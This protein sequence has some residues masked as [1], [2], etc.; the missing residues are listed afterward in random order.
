MRFSEEVLLLR[1]EMRQTLASLKWYEDLWEKQGPWHTTLKSKPIIVGRY[2]T[3]TS[4]TIPGG[5]PLSYVH[6]ASALTTIFCTGASPSIIHSLL[7][8]KSTRCIYWM[9]R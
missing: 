5:I 2:T 7:L 8:P 6:W 9:A 1:E 3:M 4:S